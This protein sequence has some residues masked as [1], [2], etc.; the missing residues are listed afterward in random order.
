MSDLTSYINSC[1]SVT[2]YENIVVEFSKP[3]FQVKPAWYDDFIARFDTVAV[4]PIKWS[5]LIVPQFISV[6][7]K[8]ISSI[9]QVKSHFDA[10]ADDCTDLSDQDALNDA[11]S[12]LQAIIQV[13]TT[14]SG[15]CDS[16]TRDLQQYLA[17]T[18]G[19]D[20]PVLQQGV[21]MSMSQVEA[22][23]QRMSFLNAEMA[24]LR[25]QIDSLE[26]WWPFTAGKINDAKKKLGADE[27]E[28]ATLQHDESVLQSMNAS[29]QA[30]LDRNQQACPSVQYILAYWMNFYMQL[31]NL[32]QQLNETMDSLTAGSPSPLLSI[33]TDESKRAWDDLVSMARDLAGVSYA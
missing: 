33:L 28:Y 4:D 5:N 9:A 6:P 1:N 18:A 7:Q 8:V 24:S 10:I 27:S 2:A 17:M 32:Q 15:A 3:S 29:I 30:I 21:S 31:Q 20:C 19:N 14:V 23:A 11:R 12:Q 26:P 16:L 13:I 22:N 25:D